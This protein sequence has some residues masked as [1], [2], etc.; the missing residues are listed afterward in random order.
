MILSA[1]LAL[2]LV[3]QPVVQDSV[4]VTQVRQDEA[5]TRDG[6]MEQLSAPGGGILEADERAP[7]DSPPD[8]VP[9]L[10]ETDTD[11]EF[12]RVEGMDRCSAELL[13]AADADYC[14]RRLETRSADFTTEN[15][16]RLTAE[17][18]LI[19]ERFASVGDGD[20]AESSRTIGRRDPRADDRNLQA[21]ASITLGPGTVADE[22]TADEGASGLPSET[23][24]LIEAIVERL[25]DPS[26]GGG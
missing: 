10:S 12:A 17:Q 13:S 20:V 7:D 19:G 2:L 6:P 9:Q 5:E 4:S 14:A 25:A 26:G 15:E 3:G 1:T 8:A 22:P 23:Q 11:V 21:L 16:A 24:A 18:V